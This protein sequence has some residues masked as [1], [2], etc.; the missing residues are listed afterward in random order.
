MQKYT[1]KNEMPNF[2]LFFFVPSQKF[3]LERKMRHTFIIVACWLGLTVQAQETKP[4][5]KAKVNKQVCFPE[6][7][8]PGNFSG[9]TWLGGNE[10]AVVSDKSR[11]DGFFIFHINIDPDTGVISHAYSNEFRSADRPNRDMEGITY[12]AK[13]STIYISGEADNRIM[14]YRLDNG[15]RTGRQFDIPDSLMLSNPNYGFES[16]T[17]N[18]STHR[19]WTV[20]ESTLPIDGTPASPSNKTRNKLRLLSFD[21]NLKLVAQYNYEMD[22]PELKST[23]AQN[24][25]I[26]VSELCALDDGR[27]LVLERELYAPSLKLGSFVNCKLY[28]VDPADNAPIAPLEKRLVTKFKT[29][30]TGLK[31]NFA[32]YEGMC[33]G[34]RLNDGRQVLIMICDSQNQHKGVLKDWLQTIILE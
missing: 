20:S 22:L 21:E 2:Y 1:K 18:A 27:V 5:I 3:L 24:Y 33:L 30:M 32:N 19:Y 15:Q 28:V 34:P 16:L 31:N 25:C 17:Y 4:E 26:G 10:Y 13:D 14:E 6:T 8:P 9:I 11:S 29:S 12:N 7:V 23:T